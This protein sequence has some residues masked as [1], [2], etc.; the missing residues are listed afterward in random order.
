MNLWER[1][2]GAR[3]AAT[4]VA[5]SLMIGCVIALPLPW[6]A[7]LTGNEALTGIVSLGDAPG[8]LLALPV[9]YR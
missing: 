5:G 4:N 9:A 2:A 3:G 1:V 6:L 7:S 8:F